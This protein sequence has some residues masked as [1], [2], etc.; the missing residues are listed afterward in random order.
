MLYVYI[1]VGAVGIILVIGVCVLIGTR[2]A[3]HLNESEMTH[4]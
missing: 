3:E 1:A 2:K 4:T